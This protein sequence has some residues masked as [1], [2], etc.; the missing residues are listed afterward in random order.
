M[1]M[2]FYNF[3]LDNKKILIYLRNKDNQMKRIDLNIAQ[4]NFMMWMMNSYNP[5]GD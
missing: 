2:K 5:K 1:I 4:I 3:L